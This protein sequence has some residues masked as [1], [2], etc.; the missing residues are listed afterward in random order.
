MRGVLHFRRSNR[1]RVA[2]KAQN[3]V[4]E[5][6]LAVDLMDHFS[7]ALRPTIQRTDAETLAQKKLLVEC[8]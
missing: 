4:V 1:P 2:R 8:R 5:V 3:I 6:L 7:H